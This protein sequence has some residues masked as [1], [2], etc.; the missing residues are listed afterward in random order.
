MTSRWSGRSFSSSRGRLT[1]SRPRPEFKQLGT[2]IR[3]DRYPI[4]PE[5][6]FWEGDSKVVKAGTNKEITSW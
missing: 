6:V 5:L 1:G 4:G 3:R 2:F